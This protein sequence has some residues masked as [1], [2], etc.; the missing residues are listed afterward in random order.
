MNLVESTVRKVLSEP[1]HQ[2]GFCYDTF[3]VDVEV[4]C[5]G[6]VSE[7]TLSFRTLEEAKQVKVGYKFSS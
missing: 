4:N 3:E 1:R 5:W 2:H 7:T 6:H